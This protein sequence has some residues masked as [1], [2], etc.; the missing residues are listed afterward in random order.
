MEIPSPIRS[1]APLSPEQGELV[2]QLR[3]AELLNDALT[4]PGSLGITYNR[5]YNYSFLNIILLYLQGVNEPVATYKRWQEMGRQVKKGSKATS[6]LRPIMRKET[7]DGGEEVQRLGGFKH[8]KCLF[9]VSETEGD[10]LPEVAPPD[11]NPTAALAALDIEEVPFEHLDGNVAGYSIDR[12][13]AINRS[14]PKS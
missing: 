13:F 5:F 4:M 8:V 6:I 11:W 1:E 9:T 3:W 12:Q 7:N 14:L 2:R 10:E